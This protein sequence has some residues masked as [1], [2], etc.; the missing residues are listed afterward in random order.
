MNLATVFLG[1]QGC[2]KAF[3]VCQL[4]ELA[5]WC[6]AKGWESTTDWSCPVHVKLHKTSMSS[7][8]PFFF[9]FCWQSMREVCSFSVLGIVFMK[10]DPGLELFTQASFSN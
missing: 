2:K 6:G 5:M 7:A 4:P 10:A 8:P 1:L 3:L 9:L